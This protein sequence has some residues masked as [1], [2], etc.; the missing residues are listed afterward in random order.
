[1]NLLPNRDRVLVEADMQAKNSYRLTDEVT[2][3]ME[4]NIENYNGRETN[5]VQ[6]YVTDQEGFPKRAE[7]LVD[8]N[9]LHPTN[10]IGDV[11]MKSN[12]KLF[13]VPLPE[14]YCYRELKTNKTDCAIFYGEWMPCENFLIIERVFRP[15]AGILE[16]IE[17]TELKNILFCL[18]GEYKHKVLHTAKWTDYEIIF[19]NEFGREDSIIRMRNNDDEVEAVS[20]DLT[21][22]LLSGKL[23]IGK[24]ASTATTFEEYIK[25]TTYE[26]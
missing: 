2:I 24:T 11:E 23:L 20:D 19:Q 25:K 8:H 12:Y 5:A 9:S 17:P 21:N 14:V 18:Q 26:K 3:Q 4:R 10:L 1:M 7:V 16:G 13:S 22:L 15:Y 6:G